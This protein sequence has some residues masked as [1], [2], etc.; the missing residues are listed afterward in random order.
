[1]HLE[2]LEARITLG[3]PTWLTHQTAAAYASFSGMLHTDWLSHGRSWA[4]L[5]IAV[6][7]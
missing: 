2:G 4:H 3:R 6:F 1:M 7:P 5:G